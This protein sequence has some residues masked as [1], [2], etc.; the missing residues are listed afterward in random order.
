MKLN[1]VR[2]YYLHHGQDHVIFPARYWSLDMPVA[3]V[4]T[5]GI[6]E[7]ELMDWSAYVGAGKTKGENREETLTHV[8]EY[9]AKFSLADAGHFFYWL[10]DAGVPYR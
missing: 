3:I 9:G 5:V 2:R 10:A 6:F 4:A 1:E 7:R 8:A